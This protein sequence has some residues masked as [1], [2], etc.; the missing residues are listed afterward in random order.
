MYPKNQVRFLNF[1]LLC[2]ENQVRISKKKDKNIE[3]NEA[4]LCTVSVWKNINI[5]IKQYVKIYHHNN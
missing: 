5:I 1:F 4:N 3:K 2:S